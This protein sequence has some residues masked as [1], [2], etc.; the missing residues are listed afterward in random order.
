VPKKIRF[1]QSR[2]LAHPGQIRENNI[3]R[4]RCTPV[5]YMTQGMS[6]DTFA[7]Y[8]GRAGQ[9]EEGYQ[10]DHTECDIFIYFHNLISLAACIP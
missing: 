1:V 10:Q 9:H 8:L 7:S 6:N 2:A 4:D 3:G 5:A